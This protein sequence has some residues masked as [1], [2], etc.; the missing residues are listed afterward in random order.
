MTHR[1]FVDRYREPLAA[2]SISEGS[3]QERVEQTRTAMGLGDHDV[4]LGQ[5]K[6]RLLL[7]SVV[8]VSENFHRLSFR[9]R[10]STGF[11]F[12]PGLPEAREP[13]SADPYRPEFYE[14]S[15]QL[16][17]AV[18]AAPFRGEYEDYDKRKSFKDDGYGTHSALMSNC[19]T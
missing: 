12:A 6:V 15:Q 2:L 18:H 10:P 5:Y 3:N 19:M 1:E 17:L 13:G 11:P 14:S 7:H 8:V 4:V 16:S 9:T